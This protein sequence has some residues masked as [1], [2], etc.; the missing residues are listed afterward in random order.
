MPMPAF[1]LSNSTE[2]PYKFL[3]NLSMPLNEEN[4]VKEKLLP[5]VK[6]P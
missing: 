1:I 6:K 5:S 4:I 3:L 2:K